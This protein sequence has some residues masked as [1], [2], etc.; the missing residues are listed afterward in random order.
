MPSLLSD[1][2]KACLSWA[3]SGKSSWEIG[4]ILSISEHTVVFHIKNAM[5]KLNANSRAVA[6]FRAIRLGLIEP[7][8]EPEPE[9][10]GQPRARKAS[11]G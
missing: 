8:F 9:P 11:A 10:E 3:V 5:R 1:R 2:E 7:V 4:K 6:A